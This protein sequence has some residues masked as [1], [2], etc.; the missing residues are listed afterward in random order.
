MSRLS[1]RRVALVLRVRILNGDAVKSERN[2]WIPLPLLLLLAFVLDM[3]VCVSVHVASIVFLAFGK[4]RWRDSF[5]KLLSFLRA[6]TRFFFLTRL[7]YGL[8]RHGNA[9]EIRV[10]DG[11]SGFVVSAE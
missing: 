7:S 5:Q 8:L 6:A 3:F 11:G 4:K 1:Q 10:V 9:L 2:I